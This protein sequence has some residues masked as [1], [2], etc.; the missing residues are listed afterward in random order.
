MI[1]AVELVSNGVTYTEGSFVDTFWSAVIVGFLLATVAWL[2]EGC[3]TVTGRVAVIWSLTFIV[4]L[5]ASTT[6]SRPP[7][8]LLLLSMASSRSA[9]PSAGSTRLPRQRARRR[10]D[11]RLDQL[12]AG[13]RRGLARAGRG[14]NAHRLAHVNQ[15]SGRDL[16]GLGRAGAQDALQARPR[17]AEAPRSAP[18]PAPGTRRRPR[19][20]RP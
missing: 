15:R 16:A 8:R 14:A 9:T 13:A 5:A 10:G 1:S 11:R 18:G 4:S 12:R 3:D 6:A 7:L 20:P 2:V 17:R 19:P